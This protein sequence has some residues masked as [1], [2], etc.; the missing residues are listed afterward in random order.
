MDQFEYASQM[1]TQRASF[2]IPQDIF[3]TFHNRSLYVNL[4][5]SDVLLVKNRA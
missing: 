3:S 1:Q 5:V 2:N 4:G